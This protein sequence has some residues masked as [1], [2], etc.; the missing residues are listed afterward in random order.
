MGLPIYTN[1]TEQ[2][3]ERDCSGHKILWFLQGEKQQVLTPIKKAKKSI[4]SIEK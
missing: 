3:A 4:F 1:K 2:I